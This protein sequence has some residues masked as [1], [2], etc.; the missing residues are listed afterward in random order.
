MNSTQSVS[1]EALEQALA[2][3]NL[4][5]DNLGTAAPIVDVLLKVAAEPGYVSVSIDG[6]ETWHDIPTS[7]ISEARLIGRQKC[8]DHAHPVAMLVLKSRLEESEVT[9]DFIQFLLDALRIRTIQGT[10]VRR[11]AGSLGDDDARSTIRRVSRIGRGPW[12][13]GGFG[14]GG[15]FGDDPCG[16]GGT[17]ECNYYWVEYNCSPLA[18]LTYIPCYSLVRHCGCTYTA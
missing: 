9:G 6:C 11:F 16:P 10:G 3:D 18:P 7:L 12:G 17:Y 14:G 15:V 8:G 4:A 5:A 2:A 1:G 13:P